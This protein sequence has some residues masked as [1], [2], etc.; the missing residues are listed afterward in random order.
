M[1]KIDDANGKKILKALGKNDNLE[2]LDLSSN[3]IANLSAQG[4]S[5]SLKENKSIKSLDL[6]NTNFVMIPELIKSVENSLS[7]VNID[8]RQ[9]KVTDGN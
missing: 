2:F 4:L 5:E 7:L 1:N 8:L 9:T 6:S 3:E